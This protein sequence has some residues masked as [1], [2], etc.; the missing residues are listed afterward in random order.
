MSHSL[1]TELP[2][3]YGGQF[4]TTFLSTGFYLGDVVQTVL[5][6]ADTDERRAAVVYVQGLLQDRCSDEHVWRDAIEVLGRLL[7]AHPDAFKESGTWYDGDSS[8]LALALT[9]EAAYFAMRKPFPSIHSQ[10]D[11]AG[12]AFK[13]LKYFFRAMAQK[14]ENSCQ[15]FALV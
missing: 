4:A 14:P 3:T 9:R 2:A 8:I 12:G 5:Q 1:S 15:L 6:F 13:V 11:I 10:D 7:D